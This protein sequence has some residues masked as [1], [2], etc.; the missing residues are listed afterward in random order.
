MYTSI[1]KD[2]KM[3]TKNIPKRDF[4]F[5]YAYNFIARLIFVWSIVERGHVRRFCKQKEQ[6]GN[7]FFE[8]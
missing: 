7:Y 8:N 2:I 5:C 6:A 3:N 1:K 4:E